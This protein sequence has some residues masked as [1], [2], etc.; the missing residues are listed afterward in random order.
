ME[1]CFDEIFNVNKKIKI[2]NEK[3]TKKP[4]PQPP[5]NPIAYTVS[6]FT[7]IKENLQQKIKNSNDKKDE[8]M[9]YFQEIPEEILIKICKYLTKEELSILAIVNTKFRNF[10]VDYFLI[11]HSGLTFL[12]TDNQAVP[13][14][15]SQEDS[16]S[17]LKLFSDIGLLLKRATFLFRT[18]ERIS[19][20]IYVIENSF[21]IPSLQTFEYFNFRT[22]KTLVRCYGKIINKLTCGW[23]DFECIELFNVLKGNLVD[24]IFNE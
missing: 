21:G 13:V 15:I 20:L 23:G 18:C 19:L 12:L 7:N 10:I 5:F 2:D 6:L 1:F 16:Q 3:P 24:L 8:T 9:G 14:E 17:M 11:S 22:I 4:P